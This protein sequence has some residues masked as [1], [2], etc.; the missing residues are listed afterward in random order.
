M[1]VSFFKCIYF[2]MQFGP[3]VVICDFWQA[4]DFSGFFLKEEK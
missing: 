3:R 4:C 2:I 1:F